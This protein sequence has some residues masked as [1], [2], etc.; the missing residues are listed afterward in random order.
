MI[1]D[2]GRVFDALV[3]MAYCAVCPVVV[4]ESVTAPT[5][6]AFAKGVPLCAGVD[7]VAPSPI[8]TALAAI[9]PDTATAAVAPVTFPCGIVAGLVMDAV[10]VFAVVGVPVMATVTTV[11]LVR[12]AEPTV[13]PAGNPVIP[14]KFEPV[15][16]PA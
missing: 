12:V 15:I 2:V 8:A 1:P 9:V 10:L 11:P 3:V 5:V 13:S 7:T 6:I 16:V 14:V 4:G